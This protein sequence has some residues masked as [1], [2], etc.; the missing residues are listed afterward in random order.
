VEE[1]IK[2]PTMESD[3]QVLIR[4]EEMTVDRAQWSDLVA[5]I[6][7]VATGMQLQ[8]CQKRRQYDYPP[9]SATGTMSVVRHLSAPEYVRVQCDVEAEGGLQ[10]PGL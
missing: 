2:K 3:C 5:G 1:W 6:K 7:A 9:I 10:V 4:A 8:S